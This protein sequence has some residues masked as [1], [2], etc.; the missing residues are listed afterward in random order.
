MIKVGIN[1]VEYS[2]TPE[3]PIIHIFG[4]TE[5]GV[6]ERI[7]VLNFRPYFYIAADDV[8]TIPRG[9]LEV[10]DT[11]RIS[12]RK[13]SVRRVYTKKPSDVRELR[14]KYKHCEGDIVFTSRFMIDCGLTGGVSSP[15]NVVNY[16]ELTPTDVKARARVCMIDI[17]CS[18]DLGWPDPERSPIICITCHDSFEEAYVT[19]LLSSREGASEEI[20]RKYERG[21]LETGCFREAEHT[22]LVYDDEKYMLVEFANYIKDRDP[23]VLSGWNI[24]GFDLPY[25]LGRMD[26]LGISTERLARLPGSTNRPEVRGRAIFDL[27]LGYQKMHLTK[28]ESYRLDAIAEEELGE[29]KIHYIGKIG[30]LWREDP[31][32]LV[33]Y[34]LQDVRICVML[35]KKDNIVEFFRELARYVGCPLDRTTSSSAIVDVYVLRKAHDKYVLPSKGNSNGEK[36]EGAVVFEPSQGLRENVVVLDLKSLYPMITM[37]INASPDT[38]DP[39]GELWAPSGARFKKE[40]DGLARGILAELLKERDAKKAERNMHKFGSP[41][42]KLLNMQQDVLK[43][44]MNTYYGV[45]GNAQFRL[46]D[47][48]IGAAITSVGRAILEHTREV[49]K[50]EGY[51]VIYG[52]TDSV[53]VQLPATLSQEETIREARRLEKLLNESY[54]GFAKK[55]LNADVHYFSTKFEKIYQR[56]FQAGTKK[57]YAGLLTWKEGQQVQEVDIVGYE[58]KRSD[59]PRVTRDAQKQ[60]MTLILGG[61]GF[62]AVREYLH[63]VLKK[64]RAGAYPL[65]DIGIPGGIGKALE[66]YESPDAQIRGAKYANDVFGAGFG[67]GSKPKRVYVKAVTGKYKRTD[68]I[69]FEYGEQVPPEFVVDRELMLEK[70]LKKPISRITDALGWSWESLDPTITTFSTTFKD[71]EF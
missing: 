32:N 36:F 15:K 12:I 52:D 68:V 48:E 21:G 34:N 28:K 62:E 11:E 53:M 55:T 51:A 38:K 70:T 27:L 5:K 67:K 50:R 20:C 35:N 29:H 56:F 13:E 8:K 39:N 33:N 69:A 71:C 43:V 46:S 40:P 7:D 45:S 10:D 57:R 30:N 19:F 6:A 4:R 23:D 59:S 61:Q 49:V 3:G 14:E 26:V 17:E 31:A 60:V 18:D 44:I 25:I 22:V 47:R 66:D 58:M 63:T 37:T 42:Y 64:Y 1:Q 65:D 41:E 2:S 54:Q 24:T 16:K 9:Q